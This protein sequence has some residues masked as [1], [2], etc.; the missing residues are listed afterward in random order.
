MTAGGRPAAAAGFF[1]ARAEVKLA[2]GVDQHTNESGELHESVGDFDLAV[3]TR[4][5]ACCRQRN[6]ELTGQGR[7]RLLGWSARRRD[8]GHQ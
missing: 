2:W 3:G 1:R 5:S 4:W 8:R 6:T 7:S